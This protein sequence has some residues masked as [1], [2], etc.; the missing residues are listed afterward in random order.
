M[1]EVG[2]GPGVAGVFFFKVCLEYVD[3]SRWV[4]CYFIGGWVS[5]GV[6]F[7]LVFGVRL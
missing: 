2:R 1:D 6:K 3:D 4:C 7:G 5:Y